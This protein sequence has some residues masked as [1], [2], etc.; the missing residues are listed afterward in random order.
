MLFRSIAI[1]YVLLE[2]L[3][4]YAISTTKYQFER[5]EMSGHVAV[6][7]GGR[8]YDYK[9][10]CSINEL[11]QYVH[12]DEFLIMSAVPEAAVRRFFFGKPFDAAKKILERARLDVRA[13]N[14]AKSIREYRRKLE[15]ARK[16]SDTALDAVAAIW[17][18]REIGR[19][20]CR[21][22]V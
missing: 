22:R 14:C 9:G 16:Y 13:G 20:S 10:K 5:G 2:G 3:G 18:G 8:F 17:T 12:G 19:A 15:A 21:E 4:T 7:Y 11:L 1:N 6:Y